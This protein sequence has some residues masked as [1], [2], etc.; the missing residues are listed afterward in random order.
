MRALDR[1]LLRD[2]RRL[3]MQGLAI[4]LVLAA[5][6]AT[7]LLAIGAQHALEET[8]AAWYERARFAHV[9]AEATRA[10]MEAAERLALIPG[11]AAVE[12][13]ISRLGLIDVAGMDAP[14]TGRFVSGPRDGAQRLNLPHMRLGRPPDPDRP[15]EVLV[16]EA[17]AEAHGL[18][19]GDGFEA[20]LGGR[21]RR[22][23]IAGVALSPE[24][25]YA[26]GPGDIVPDDRRFG[27]F[28]ASYRTLA[29]A[30]DL[31]GAFD[32]V[33]IRLARGADEAA[34]IAAV[35]AILAPYGGV[36]AYG[37]ADQQSHA[38]L[39]GE[40]RQLRGMAFSIPPIFLGVAAFLTNVA[41]ARIVALERE[42]IGLLKAVGYGAGAIAAHYLK[43]VALLAAA[44]VLIGWGA[45]VW[46]GRLVTELFA[47]T[48]RFPFLLF[49]IRADLFAISALAALGAALGG[50]ALSIRAVV[51]LPPA[52]AMSPPAPP[53]YRRLVIDRLAAAARAP[54]ALTMALR[55]ILRWPVRA[56]LTTLGLALSIA[57]AVGTLFAFDSVDFIISA[58]FDR[59]ERQDATLTFSETAPERAALDAARL[60]GVLAAEPFRAVA[61]RLEAGPRAERVALLGRP[62]GADL[63]RIVDRSLAPVDP[64][65]IGL[66]LSDA[67]AAKL[68]VG[69]GDRVRVVVLGGRRRAAEV[70]VTAVVSQY[71]GLNA[72]MEIDALGR[73]TGD[74]ER[75]DGVQVAVDP[76]EEAALFA[77]VK[78]TPA[79]AALALRNRA[80]ARFRALIDEN[81]GT[82]IWVYG[83][84]SALIAL[85]VVYNSVRIRLSERAREL[86]SLRVLGFTRG[87]TTTMLLLELALLGLAA[88][89]LGWLL[90]RGLAWIVS[91][92][93]QSDLYR[94]PVVI[95]P[96]TYALATALFLAVAAV[97]A[98]DAWRRIDRLDLIAVLKT[99]E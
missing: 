70:P 8:R 98:L 77:A 3:R 15:G 19:P 11:V 18:R 63:S 26:L 20:I 67:L 78:R 5:G 57:V 38:Y 95:E 64:P 13:R 79:V 10:P 93:L 37:R 82:M 31:D 61:V 83:G 94:V 90:G 69:R 60:P 14:A 25:I 99:R 2:L 17:F 46:L 75:I 39:D 45:G 24:A 88:I 23:T 49:P 65:E 27:Q 29:A 80:L 28:L 7:L 35:D 89:P 59:A 43:L 85:G 92:G 36:G 53:V 33:T 86:A 62:R 97:S 56:A 44:G 22:M 71:F 6:V 96:E 9:F 76:R 58:T 66:A 48:Y 74:R 40:L 32:S 91:R 4:A 12:P 47:E 55:T 16:S 30:F 84:F 51:A 81:V 50:A 87:E 73:L 21:K 34:V 42:Q 41:V 54:Q 52:V 72:Y 68:G 1:K